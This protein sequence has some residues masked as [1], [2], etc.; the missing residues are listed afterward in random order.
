MSTEERKTK[1]YRL[2]E[3]HLQQ[4]LTLVNLDKLTE[5]LKATAEEMG[6]LLTELS[7]S[8]PS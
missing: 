5:Q 1:E 6:R 7:A 8:D 3:L 2:Q 4:T